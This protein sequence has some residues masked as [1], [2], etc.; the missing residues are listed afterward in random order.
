MFFKKK[1]LNIYLKCLFIKKNVHKK[2]VSHYVLN[3]LIYSERRWK[4]FGKLYERLC[5]S[6]RGSML[7]S[8]LLSEY[9]DPEIDNPQ[10]VKT[11]DEKWQMQIQ[12]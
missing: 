12:K 7:T 5:L 1:I 6:I 8:F 2:S 10:A 3:V 11:K 9:C 4:A